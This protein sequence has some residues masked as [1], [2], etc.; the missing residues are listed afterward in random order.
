MVRRE[1]WL[2]APLP[3]DLVLCSLQIRAEIRHDT[4]SQKPDLVWGQRFEHSV[5]EEVL[6]LLQIERP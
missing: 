5:R 6:T 1:R 3:L 2:F 4:R